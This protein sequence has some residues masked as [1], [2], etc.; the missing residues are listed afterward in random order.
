M[1]EAIRFLHALAQALATMALY[2]PGHPSARRASEGAWQALTALLR[3]EPLAAFL[4]LGGAPVYGSR[5]LHELADWPWSG[6]L[7][8]AAVQRIEFDRAI[9]L[10]S[11]ESLLGLLQSRL[12]D[13]EAATS[14][15]VRLTGVSFGPVE[16]ESVVPEDDA[17]VSAGEEEAEAMV[18]LDLQDEL[19]ALRYVFA[20]A[21]EGRLARAEAEA[22]VRLLVGLVELHPLP[23]ANVADPAEPAAQALNTTLM[24]MAVGMRLGLDGAE[25]QRLGVAALWHDIGL[26]QLPVDLATTLTLTA[27]ERAIVERHTVLGAKLLLQQGGHGLQLAALVAYEHHLR[28]DG[29]GYPSR[30]VGQGAHWASSLVGAAA[31]YH[32]LRTPRPYRAAWGAE[33][34][35][36]YLES[37][38]GTVF[39]PV[40][41]RLVIELV[42]S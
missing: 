31:T 4:F 11:F 29:T 1:S 9:T 28:P 19:E 13:V 22:V 27:E 10:E 41:A 15:E 7:A 3:A 25:R 38:A 8:D 20:E 5:A 32:A 40:A 37:G 26:M 14:G 6:R 17:E 2:S 16:V 12:A 23:Q 34:A 33:R 21:R 30:R 39:D 24:V 35:L 18:L 42:S 36:H